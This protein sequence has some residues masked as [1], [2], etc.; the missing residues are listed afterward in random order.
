M[1]LPD[2]RAC[3]RDRAHICRAGGRGRRA[4][5]QLRRLLLG[6]EAALSVVVVVVVDGSV[7]E[8]LAIE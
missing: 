4:A 2:S 6:L 5:R 7:D 8:L 1:E 3:P